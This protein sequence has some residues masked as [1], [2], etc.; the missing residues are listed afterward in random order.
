MR[1]RSLY[2]KG[3]KSFA[4]ETVLN[5]N[6]DVIGVVGPN[7]SG[8]SNIV[9]AI[10]WVLGEQKGK[11]LRL[12]AMSD[13]IFN[14]TKTK[15]EAAAATVSLTFENDK[16]L[17]P[18]EYNNVTISRILYRSGESEYRLN[19]VI[20]RLKDINTLLMDTGIGSNSY[21]IIVLGMVDD[22]LADKENARRR[23]F[24]QA[25]GISKYKV[26]K[27]ETLSKLKSAEED[28]NRIDDLLYEIDGNLKSLEKQAKR[29]QKYNELK[30]QYK[31]LSIKHAIH[32]IQSLKHR[33]KQSSEQ[34]RLEQDKYK[35]L[36]VQIYQLQAT[37][38][39]EKK[40]N[41]DKELEVSNK[42]KG[43][44]DLMHRIRTQ[45]GEKSLVVQNIGFKKV[46]KKN[47][48]RTIEE[49]E[50]ELL[51]L[52]SEALLLLKR[53]DQEKASE[54]AFKQKLEKSSELYNAIKAEHA[55]AKN[56]FDQNQVYRQGIEK[57]IF[58]YDKNIAVLQNNIENTTAETER[59]MQ[60]L[61]Y[62]E[63][64][65]KDVKVQAA[66][67]KN[68]LDNKSREFQLLLEQEN[69]RKAAISELE[70]K[71]DKLTDTVNKV[72]RD[73]D[74]RK[75]EYD[76]LKGMIDNFEGFPESV[77]FLSEN[78]RKDPVILT[79]I[80]QVDEPYKAAIEQYL[81]SF[82]NYFIVKNSDEATS[83]I[84]MLRD[85]Q[86]GKANFFLLD[87]IPSVDSHKNH[88]EWTVPALDKVHVEEQ[89]QPLIT[90][91]LKD[92]YVI[93]TDLESF[94][95]SSEYKDLIFLSASGTFQR[96]S[97]VLS[98]GSVGLF[99]GKKIGRKQNL[100]KLGKD[101]EQ[102]LV[103]KTEQEKLFV[104][105][106]SDLELLKSKDHQKSIETLRK[107]IQGLEEKALKFNMQVD[108]FETFKK[109]VE[110][111]NKFSA[112]T[113]K[114]FETK[115]SEIRTEK[116][117]LANDLKL[118]LQNHG[119]SD[120]ELDSLYQK[121][122]VAGEHLNQDNIQLI[123]QQ[124]LIG[125]LSQDHTYKE[126]RV[127]E[128]KHKIQVDKNRLTTEEREQIDLED[129]LLR[130]DESLKLLY[131][132]KK[133]Y[134]ETLS[135]A[136]EG[137]FK[138]R[139]VINE[140][141]EKIRQL[142]R[143]QNQLQQTIQTLKDDYTESRFQINA[144]GDRLKIEFDVN[145]NDIINQEPES[146]TDLEMLTAEVEKIR[147]RILN[148]GEINPLAVE[149]YNEMNERFT[150]IKTQRQDILEARDSLMDTIKEIENT[151]TVQ[152]VEAFN[153]VRE[154]FITV[155]RSLFTEDDTCD[156]ILLDPSNPLDSEIEIVAKP[157]GKKP[158][159]LSQLSGGEKT[160]TATALLFALYL[161]K[162]AP[163]CIFDEVDAPLDDANIQKFNK[164]VKN[165]SKE[166]QFIIVTHNKS[167]MAEVDTLYGV[168]MQEP[169][170][171]AVSAVDFR[172]YKHEPVLETINQ[173]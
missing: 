146:D 132:E 151:A 157:K 130:L 42:Q 44:G 48:G 110:S 156:L 119:S 59:R 87:E 153:K 165:F 79:D 11:E 92:T 60:D 63:Q 18:T 98:G 75:N 122:S 152:F 49:S 88:P 86:K 74:S 100:E 24:E 135:E 28:L 76:L 65:L 95:F 103:L 81:E 121:L 123:R 101:I 106:K 29:T 115:M 142:T 163:F 125:N 144:V 69:H 37:L 136:E 127:A 21:A 161:L 120:K 82:L 35:E 158:K 22:I 118:S 164:I 43:L 10:R 51:K 50:Q 30:T 162:P 155:F 34:L 109:D 148:Y 20:C 62:K 145:I 17:L 53:I 57:K 2:I 6:D 107:E 1:L 36:D 12:E 4:N 8:K 99:E 112:Q 173:N 15:K 97:V 47:V 9:D 56:I 133:N 26:R 105:V 16:N 46:N 91:L 90:Y 54:Q 83:A 102:S 45:E 117:I 166:S 33:Y 55:N 126:G 73:L 77:R 32:S 84:R 140:L 114:D 138:A 96:S 39:K 169:G 3:F 14:G 61:S 58:E 141:E 128:Y 23:M 150:T 171:S 137:Y 27:R 124:N 72:N 85:G 67:L 104:S 38:E 64:N 40:K 108:S 172:S 170:V 168:Y 93:D 134:Q 147:N 52:E 167:T 7:G 89:Y 149:T 68:Q 13:V 71:R 80:L 143:V 129:Q 41:L 113:I 25:A 154:N 159:S 111:K 31:E 94:S 70:V 139:N 19:N 116:E 131:T 78:W 66:E 5:F 160:L